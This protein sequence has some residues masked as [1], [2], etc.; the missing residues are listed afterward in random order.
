MHEYSSDPNFYK[1]LETNVHNNEKETENYLKNLQKRELYGSHNGKSIY[2]GIIDNEFDR[3][4]GT[5]GFVG[6]QEKQKSACTTIGMSYKHR[7]SGRALEAIIN[8]LEYGFGDLNLHRIWAIT[9]HEN[10]AVILSHKLFGFK[11]E[12]LLRDYYFDDKN[13]INASLL[14]CLKKDYN[15]K[16]AINNL[17]LLRKISQ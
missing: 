16:R 11:E 15:Y 1:Y 2:W 9:H 6:I 3:M 7:K 14:A 13:F 5:I 12:G 17:A 4:I 10:K 8:L